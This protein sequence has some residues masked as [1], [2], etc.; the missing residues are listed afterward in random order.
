MPLTEEVTDQKLDQE[1]AAF[2]ALHGQLVL[3]HFGQF[4]AIHAG[5]L[6]DADVNQRE[7]YIR[8]HRNNPDTV[9]G[10][11]PVRESSQMPTHH[12][13]SRRIEILTDPADY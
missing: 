3:T 8:V 13:G 9:I 4:V 10:I 6:I 7:L 2:A 1:Q 12:I 5:K 11:F